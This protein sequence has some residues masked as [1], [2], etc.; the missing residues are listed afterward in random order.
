[1]EGGQNSVSSG[2]VAQVKQVLD[3]IDIDVMIVWLNILE[4]DMSVH[5]KE[6]IRDSKLSGPEWV[7]EIIYGHSDRIYEAFRMER[8]VFLNLCGLMSA[9]GL[10]KDS[11]YIRVDEQVGIF[12]YLVG[13]KNSNRDLCER[14]Q[15]S[16]ATINKYFNIVLKAVIELSKEI[17][18]PS[19]FDVVPE[20]ILMDPNHKRYFKDCVGAIDGTH[21]NASIPIS[22][23]IPY[24]GRKGS[25]TQ[26]VMCACSFDMKFTFVYAG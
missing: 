2:Q 26:N 21:I 7:R 15:R 3:D 12:L 10:L 24:R 5:T 18:K 1:M 22:Q 23:Q 25:T 20:E 9:R 17:I 8:H 11:R 16:G 4:L 13:H 14:F 6:P 19:S